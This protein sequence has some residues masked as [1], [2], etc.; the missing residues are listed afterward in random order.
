MGLGN[1]YR[2]MVIKRTGL[3]DEDLVCPREKSFMTPCVA[4]DGD[5]A[6]TNNECCVGCNVSVAEL[7]KL[8]R[9]KQ[10]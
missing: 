10:K 1:T 6:M 4:R 7:I 2:D 9:E 5:C 3:K 8:E